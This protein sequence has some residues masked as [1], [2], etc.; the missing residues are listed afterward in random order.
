M[1][2]SPIIGTELWQELI[3]HDDGVM[4]KGGEQCGIIG[5][6]GTGKTTINI[7]LAEFTRYVPK[8][9]K[10]E[11]ISDIMRGSDITQFETYPETVV[12]RGRVN[13]YWN[14]MFPENW[15]KSF[16]K[17]PF[18]PKPVV[19]LM[20]ED[21]DLIFYHQDYGEVPRQIPHLPEI[22]T[23]KDAEDMIN[24]I[25]EGSINV[26]Y[27]PQ[28]YIIDDYLVRKLKSRMLESKT[29]TGKRKAGK[30]KTKMG[31]DFE[32]PSPPMFWFEVIGRMVVHKPVHFLTMIIDEFHQMC[33]ARPSGNMW[34]IIDIFASNFV[35]LRR[36]N[37]S[38]MFTT[39][40]TS[41]I[42]WRVSDRLAKWIWLPGSKLEPK[43]SMVHTRVPSRLPI[44][45]FIIEER[46]TRFGVCQFGR[47]PK[48]PPLLRV[49]GMLE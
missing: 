43:F 32:D 4:A 8:H 1:Q 30:R 42:D 18:N 33:L 36:N 10:Y 34:H 26:V 28:G 49:E 21:D 5:K 20:H 17:Y 2:I 40:Q 48:Q 22:R 19:I 46:L 23:Y 3:Y 41:F 11:M 35:D 37:I 31:T 15:E 16:P 12:W 9:S 44:G 6:M 24:K 29:D 39:H 47:I 45:Q 14:C 7:Q 25:E 38:L 27:E 13:D